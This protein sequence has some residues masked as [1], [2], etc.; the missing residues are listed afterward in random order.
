MEWKKAVSRDKC[1]KNLM[2]NTWVVL[3]GVWIGD[4]GPGDVEP[5][6]VLGHPRG[7]AGGEG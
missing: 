6:D 5:S 3:M 1:V 7:E 2:V 4:L